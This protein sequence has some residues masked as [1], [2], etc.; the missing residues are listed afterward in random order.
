ML[1]APKCCPSNS[2]AALGPSV[3]PRMELV[4]YDA[5]G[6]LHKSEALYTSNASIAL[7]SLAVGLQGSVP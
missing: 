5:E 3:L 4:E 1:L 6:N 7:V 2:Q